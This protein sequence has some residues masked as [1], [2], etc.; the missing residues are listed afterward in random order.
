MGAYISSQLKDLTLEQV[1]IQERLGEGTFGV[2]SSVTFKGKDGFVVSGVGK[3]LAGG[4]ASQEAADKIRRLF[5]L[6]HNNLVKLHG[7]Y[8]SSQAAL[9]L[10]VTERLH[11]PLESFLQTRSSDD[12]ID[13]VRILHDV[14]SAITYLHSQQ[15]PIVHG[16]L[17]SNN[18][19]VLETEHTLIAKVTDTGL[20]DILQVT[21][22]QYVERCPSARVYLPPEALAG[23]VK[24][25]PA[26]DVF[27]FGIL[28]I[29]VLLHHMNL[30][31][32]APVFHANPNNPRKLD[33]VE[34]TT[35]SKE[36]V[37][38]L[39]AH[40]HYGLLQ[41][42]LIKSLAARPDAVSLEKE[43]QPDQVSKPI[44]L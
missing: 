37:V 36:I 16:H 39:S 41:R 34:E 30:P 43:L 10:L 12:G 20:P 26:A 23:D 27:A 8:F 38:L 33:L 2:V 32:N 1:Q 24:L 35:E 4:A 7:L 28:I 25:F 14:A 18:I 9:P 6:E 15:P 29:R 19:L 5:S 40:P 31:A 22:Q 11:T 3:Q 17:T 13:K 21:P 44:N 42:C